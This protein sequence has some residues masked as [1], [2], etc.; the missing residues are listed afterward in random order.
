MVFRLV[1]G[2][3]DQER[4]SQDEKQTIYSSSIAKGLKFNETIFGENSF[5][6]SFWQKGHKIYPESGLSSFIQ[7]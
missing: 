4:G 2:C 1:V 5:L 6:E 3:L 7:N